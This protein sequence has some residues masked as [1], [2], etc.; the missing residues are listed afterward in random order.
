VARNTRQ[1]GLDAVPCAIADRA[2]RPT[3]FRIITG[4]GPSPRHPAPPIRHVLSQLRRAECGQTPRPG[5][6]DVDRPDLRRH[7]G[8]ADAG[9]CRRQKRT[10]CEGTGEGSREAPQPHRRRHGC[11]RGRPRVDDRVS[12]RQGD[13]ECRRVS[14]CYLRG[15]AN[16]DFE[17]RFAQKAHASEKDAIVAEMIPQNRP[18]EWTLAALRGLANDG[19]QILI[20]GQLM[21]D[22]H[23]KIGDSP[24]FSQ[25]EVHPTTRL[26]ICQRRVPRGPG[27]RHTHDGVSGRCA[28]S[29][30]R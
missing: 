15:Q 14:H 22:S 21:F 18:K 20:V 7:P 26:L 10:A 12:R 6:D 2:T 25:W 5:I 17:I 23:H 1:R 8:P 16:N 3:S 9:R 13:G 29:G 4:T 24:R 11:R 19:R 27:E 30:E 28:R